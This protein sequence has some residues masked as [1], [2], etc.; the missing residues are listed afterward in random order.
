MYKM[1]VMYAF[2]THAIVAVSGVANR[3][4]IEL[5]TRT[6]NLPGHLEE[7]FFPKMF[8]VSQSISKLL[9]TLYS[10]F[11]TISASNQLE[12]KV[13]LYFDIYRNIAVS[14]FDD[15]R[16]GPISEYRDIFDNEN[17]VPQVTFSISRYRKSSSASN[18]LFG[19]G[20]TINSFGTT[21]VA[22]KR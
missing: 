15:N 19:K 16:I 6:C 3:C 11:H 21:E 8:C 2:E 20:K 14:L 10:P 12:T 9:V 17:H 1:F 13:V 5:T 22:E 18:G 4:V 7:G